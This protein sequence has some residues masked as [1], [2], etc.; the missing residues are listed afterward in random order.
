MSSIN[1]MHRVTVINLK[2]FV[3]SVAIIRNYCRNVARDSSRG[4]VDV[5]NQRVQSGELRVDA[6]QEKVTAALQNIYESIQ[7]YTPI[8][9]TSSGLFSWL[10]KRDDNTT[11]V[12]SAAPKGLYIHG[13][14]GGGKTTLM[15]LFYDCCTSIDRK[16]RVHFN[17]FMTDVHARIHDV[18][19]EEGRRTINDVRIKAKPFDPTRSVADLISENSWL[20]CFDEFQVDIPVKTYKFPASHVSYDCVC[21][22]IRSLIS[23]TR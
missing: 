16:K 20:I 22:S 15:D 21:F 11:S 9:P 6:H 7:G 2:S 1:K 19:E 8:K 14:V 3:Q 17:S 23:R 13:S 4:P 5:L 12:K 18:K 10:R